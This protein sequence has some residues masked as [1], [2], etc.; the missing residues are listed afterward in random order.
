M[1]GARFVTD[2]SLDFVARR[3]RFLGFDVAPLGGSRLEELFEFAARE[4]RVVLTLS[5]RLPR[6]FGSVAAIRLE[7]DRPESAVREI[8][9]RFEPSSPPFGRCPECNSPL[10]T[11]HPMEARGEVPGRVLRAHT[12]FR[13]CPVCGK[14]YW[15][16]T[17]VERIRQWLEAAL[18]RPIPRPGG[19]SETC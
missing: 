2:S 1:P 5:A 18:G 7:R 19:P 15:N 14:W 8:A 10:Q 11:R 9:S 3:L 17:H 6:R 12:E 16:G 13:F 4:D